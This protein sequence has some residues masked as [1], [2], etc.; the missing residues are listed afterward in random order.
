MSLC[1]LSLICGR[2]CSL[3]PWLSVSTQQVG[4]ISVPWYQHHWAENCKISLWLSKQETK[5]WRRRLST[6]VTGKARRQATALGRHPLVQEWPTHNL[7][8]QLWV[9]W[10]ESPEVPQSQRPASVN[11]TENEFWNGTRGLLSRR[12]E[13]NL[14]GMG[15]SDRQQGW[16]QRKARGQ[17]ADSQHSSFYCTSPKI[18]VLLANWKQGHLQSKGTI[19]TE[20]QTV[21]YIF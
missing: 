5:V 9:Y 11:R 3:N 17:V 20:A 12:G 15:S 14:G 13:L 6:G 8:S 2:Q 1:Q 21:I 19:F 7:A 4:Q 10:P 18:I 16:S